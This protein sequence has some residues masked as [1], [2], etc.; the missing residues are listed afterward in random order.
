MA[1]GPWNLHP[2]STAGTLRG[3][4]PGRGGW[5]EVPPHPI[6]AAAHLLPQRSQTYGF[7]PV[8]WRTWAMRELAWVKALPQIKH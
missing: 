4:A 1:G 5:V 2:P 3:A 6:R 7:S 8:C